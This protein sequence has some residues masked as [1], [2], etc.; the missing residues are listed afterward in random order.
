MAFQSS[1]ALHIQQEAV[2]LS[3]LRTSDLKYMALEEARKLVKERK[4]KMRGAGR[5]NR[6]YQDHPEGKEDS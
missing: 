6:E 5:R 4:T 3:Q 1:E 2:L